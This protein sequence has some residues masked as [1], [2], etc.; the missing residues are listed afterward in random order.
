VGGG[1]ECVYDAYERER[2]TRIQSG[3][4]WQCMGAVCEGSVRGQCMGSV[5]PLLTTTTDYTHGQC[6]PTH[7]R[8]IG[9]S[10]S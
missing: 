2:V 6:I 5:Y 9:G 3:Y 10:C 1:E 8:R 4:C 7:L